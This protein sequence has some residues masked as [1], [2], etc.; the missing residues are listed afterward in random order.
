MSNTVHPLTPQRQSAAAV[1]TPD[2]AADSLTSHDSS[3]TRMMNPAHCL[4]ES[5]VE[6]DYSTLVQLFAQNARNA[7]VS[8]LSMKS[9]RWAGGGAGVFA[10]AGLQD[11]YKSG[12]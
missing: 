6:K 5:V 11:G 3:S 7:I 4:F 2:G 1:V 12:A 9:H 10:A 8:Y